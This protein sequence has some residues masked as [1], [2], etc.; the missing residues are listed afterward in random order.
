MDT[1]DVEYLGVNIEAV[2]KHNMDKVQCVQQRVRKPVRQ[3]TWISSGLLLCTVLCLLLPRPSLGLQIEANDIQAFLNALDDD[4]GAQKEEGNSV[5]SESSSIEG[6]GSWGIPDAV[7]VVGKLFKYE[8]PKGAVTGEI[9]SY[10][11]GVIMTKM[12]PVIKM[13]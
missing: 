6:V 2:S 5:R 1:I 13:T 4:S 9:A 7:A 3:R 11:V 8:L 10:K 12:I